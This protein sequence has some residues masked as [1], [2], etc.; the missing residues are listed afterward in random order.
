MMKKVLCI[1]VALLMIVTMVPTAVLAEE[2]Q[3]TV[4]AE[5]VETVN[6]SQETQPPAPP[7]DAPT[8]EPT[9]TETPVI[10]DAPAP[11]DVPAPTD[12][13]ASEAPTDG[14]EATESP[15]PSESVLP[16][17]TPVVTI[18]VE[19]QAVMDAIAA[20]PADIT[21][22]DFDAIE[23]TGVAYLALADQASVTNIDVLLQAAAKLYNLYADAIATLP[24]QQDVAIDATILAMR[25][26]LENST[27][28]RSVAPDT[29]QTGQR[30]AD[31]C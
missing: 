7:T 1:L 22:A 13:P 25:T 2:G 21:W 23:R 4:E 17:E 9:P 19:A 10:T 20:L 11:S 31:G 14:T 30:N 29:Y 15:M 24:E 16:E 27:F 18:S 8:A 5:T 6:D 12:V 28:V 3:P 26:Q